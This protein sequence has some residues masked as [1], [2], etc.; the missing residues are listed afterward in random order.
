M[1]EQRYLGFVDSADL[2]AAVLANGGHLGGGCRGSGSG[3]LRKVKDFFSLKPQDPKGLVGAA[4][5][6]RWVGG[7]GL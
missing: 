3:L 1:D 5:D 7:W 6:L 2:V 4:V